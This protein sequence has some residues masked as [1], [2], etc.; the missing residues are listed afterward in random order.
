MYSVLI[1]EDEMLVRAGIKSSIEWSKFD[2]AVVADADDGESAYR[3]YRELKP[4]IIITDIK[5]PVMDGIELIRKIREEDKKTRIIILTCVE[6]LALARRAIS[7]GV[8][9][10]LIKLTMT[11]RETGDILSKIKNELDDEGKYSFTSLPSKKDLNLMKEKYIKEFIF[12]RLYSISE[13]GHY[14]NKHGL[15]ISPLNLVLALIEID[16]Y[17][18]VKCRFRDEKGLLIRFSM[19]N[20]IEEL[21]KNYGRGEILHDEEGRYMVILSFHDLHGLDDIS[22]ELAKILDNIQKS[23]HMYMDIRLTITT[24][25]MDKGYEH[26]AEMYREALDKSKLRFFT[27]REGFLFGRNKDDI[28][29]EASEKQS[30]MKAICWSHT[31]LMEYFKD[32]RSEAVS[33]LLK[34]DS[35]TITEE[36]FKGAVIKLVKCP[37][38]ALYLSDK[39]VT[40]MEEACIEKLQECNTAQG[41][42]ETYQEFTKDLLEYLREKRAIREEVFKAVQYIK[43]RH[44]ENISLQDIARYVNLSTNYLGILFKESLSISFKDYLLKVRIDHAKKLLLD[45]NLP[46]S[47]IASRAGFSDESY[48]NTVFRK[49]TAA[50]PGKYRKGLHEAIYERS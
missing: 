27:G 30:C 28:E 47:E 25:S 7:L 16:Q 15:R 31:A 43:E 21:L 26:L 35:L 9:G 45:T 49:I 12:Y 23:I 19:L 33:E 24:S 22:R 29:K 48:F 14:I 44:A 4:D 34:D 50:S 18:A 32:D 37:A 2:M 40:E 6:D 42:V 8:S 10:Y 1:V 3:L 41:V 11:E 5:M 20:I 38:D 46:V 17:K 39:Q 13:M 36:L